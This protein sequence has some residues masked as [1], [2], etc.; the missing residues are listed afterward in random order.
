MTRLSAATRPASCC[1]CFRFDGGAISRTALIFSGFAASG[2]EV[3]EYLASGYAEETFLWAQ[4]D[5]VSL[6]VLEGFSQVVDKRRAV[7]GFDDGV[8]DV[9]LVVS[10]NLLAEAGLHASLVCSSRV[11]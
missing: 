3:A 4:L 10:A 9:D 7:A 1:I 5:L 2:D 8:V 11:L 6:E